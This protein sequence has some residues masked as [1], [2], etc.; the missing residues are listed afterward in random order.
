MDLKER[1]EIMHTRTYFRG[2]FG[3]RVFFASDIFRPR[4]LRGSV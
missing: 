2:F 3:I 4:L 1:N